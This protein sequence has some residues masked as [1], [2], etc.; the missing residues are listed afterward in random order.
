MT[1]VSIPAGTT[2]VVSPKCPPW[3]LFCFGNIDDVLN[4]ITMNRLAFRSEVIRVADDACVWPIH[5]KGGSA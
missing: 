1:Q 5:S 4:F 2:Y 3:G